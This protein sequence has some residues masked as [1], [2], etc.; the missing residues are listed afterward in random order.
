M[1]IYLSSTFSDLAPHRAAV[2]LALRRMGH[3]VIG[4]EQYVAE[5]MKPLDRC[6]ADVRSAELYIVI[7]AWR[8]GHVPDDPAGGKGPSITRL[9]FTQAEESHKTILAFLLNPEAPWP[10]SQMDAFSPRGGQ[11]ILGFRAELGS[12][13]LSG[14]FRTPDD[15]ASQVAAAVAAQ[16]LG[17]RMVERTLREETVTQDLAPFG[18]GEELHDTTVDKI[19]HVV[20]SAGTARALQ[21]GLGDGRSWWSTRLY[22]LAVLTECVTGIR[23]LVFSRSDGSFLGM[24]TPGDVRAALCAYVPELQSFD[25]AAQRGGTSDA[26]RETERWLEEWRTH[27]SAREASIKVGVR[28]QLVVDWLGERLVRRC[29]RIDP[30]PGLTMVQ[31]QQMVDSLLPDVPVEWRTRRLGEDNT[32]DEVRL[33]VVDRDAF[34]LQL[35]RDWVGAGLPRAPIR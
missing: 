11:D 25:T 1:R 9:E 31:V 5:S 3:D 8:Y 2:D 14:I 12:R 20:D 6:R 15:L 10:P 16:G 30:E 26:E 33:M 17:R 18:R 7:A 28:P 32:G 21:V 35:A 34:G 13:Y 23:Q 4:M 24:A 27:M 19:K 29:I 22:L